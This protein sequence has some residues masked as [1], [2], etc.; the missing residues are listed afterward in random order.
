[1]TWSLETDPSG[2]ARFALRLPVSPELT[3]IEAAVSA[4]G[5]IAS[6]FSAPAAEMLDQLT[7]T[8]GAYA[9]SACGILAGLWRARRADPALLAQSPRQW[10]QP[11]GP[12]IPPPVFRGFPTLSQA[13]DP[14]SVDV[15][16]EQAARLKAAAITTRGPK[17]LSPDPRVWS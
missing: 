6:T 3:D 7:A 12:V 14:G 17:D 10:A 1:M 4:Q 13:P 9:S 5:C 2:L 16:T 15:G 11:Q 8:V